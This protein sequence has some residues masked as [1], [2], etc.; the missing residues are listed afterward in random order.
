MYPVLV[1]IDRQEGRDT[2]VP[3]NGTYRPSFLIGR[4]AKRIVT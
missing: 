2:S 4:S 3:T 1:A